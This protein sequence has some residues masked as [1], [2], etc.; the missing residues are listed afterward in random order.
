MAFVSI[1]IS[2]IARF[3]F[4]TVIRSVRTHFACGETNYGI[5]W[6]S[7]C[8]KV[9]LANYSAADKSPAD[10]LSYTGLATLVLPCL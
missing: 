1:L 2:L 8:Q 4:F 3:S 5:Q 7:D 9:R 6:W 10:W